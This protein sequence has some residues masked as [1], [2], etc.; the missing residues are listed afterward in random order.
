ML[1]EVLFP[2]I[3]ILFFPF[4]YWAF[5]GNGLVMLSLTFFFGLF[6][7]LIYREKVNLSSERKSMGSSIGKNIFVYIFIAFML[8]FMFF[9]LLGGLMGGYRNYFD[10]IIGIII[11]IFLLIVS[12]CLFDYSKKMWYFT[13]IISFL[14][15]IACL[16]FSIIFMNFIFP[17]FVITYIIFYQI[18]K[19]KKRA[20]VLTL[21]IVSFKK[22]E[23][24]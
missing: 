18:Y 4:I 13:E 11:S 20:L 10:H 17:F 2:I 23:F 8:I 5:D 24:C 19:S 16:L 1:S 6:L 7:L 21:L 3:F 12:S 22:R 15:M 14:F 9:C